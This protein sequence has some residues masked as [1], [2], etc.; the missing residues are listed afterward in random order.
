[1]KKVL[2][3][4]AALLYLALAAALP[5]RAQQNPAP[6]L[7]TYFAEWGVPRAQWADMAKLMETEQG[8]LDKLVDDG[9]P[10]ACGISEN[11]V[12]RIGGMSH[13]DWFEASSIAGIL[14][15]LDALSASASSSPVLAASRHQDFLF[16]S[17]VYGSRSGSYHQGYLWAAHFPIKPRQ[18]GTWMRTFT[19]FVRPVLD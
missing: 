10:V 8:T 4:F 15:S 5:A 18:L 11:Q 16:E 3:G 9:T 6:M 17:S 13:G 12:H 14:K 19:S 2:P 1:M 7:Y